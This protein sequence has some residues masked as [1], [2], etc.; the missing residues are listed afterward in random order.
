V[1]AATG[2][3]VS[4]AYTP[5]NS[6][7]DVFSVKGKRLRLALADVAEAHRPAAGTSLHRQTS[8]GQLFGGE[9]LARVVALPPG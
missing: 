6:V 1:T 5:A 3:M 7:L 8:D 4:A 9:A 2:P